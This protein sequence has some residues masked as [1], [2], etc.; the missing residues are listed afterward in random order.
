MEVQLDFRHRSGKIVRL[1][2]AL[3]LVAT[4]EISGFLLGLEKHRLYL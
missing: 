2:T 4:L 1:R 3:V